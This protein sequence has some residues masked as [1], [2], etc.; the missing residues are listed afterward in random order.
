MEPH[1]SAFSF[2]F[3][4]GIG[5]ES[6][7]NL[8]GTWNEIEFWI[9]HWYYCASKLS[10]S[11]L[12]P[13]WLWQNKPFITASWKN[14]VS[15]HLRRIRT[16]RYFYISGVSEGR[17]DLKLAS[18]DFPFSLISEASSAVRIILFW[19]NFKEL[20]KK[21]EHQNMFHTCFCLSTSDKQS[22]ILFTSIV[23]SCCHY[24]MRRRPADKQLK[25]LFNEWFNGWNNLLS[26][27]SVLVANDVVPEV[28]PL[29]E[30]GF[31]RHDQLISDLQVL[32]VFSVH[33]LPCHP[34]W[35]ACGGWSLFASNIFFAKRRCSNS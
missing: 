10:L 28:H 18:K 25:E 30:P 27:H 26:F 22:S 1:H 20:K 32:M 15:S 2:W 3:A 21:N 34:S 33:R 11:L 17:C 29:S 23:F 19:S 24:N 8:T 31:P 16:P 6:F 14:G 7:E 13:Y 12:L 4:F 5:S 35:W 9:S